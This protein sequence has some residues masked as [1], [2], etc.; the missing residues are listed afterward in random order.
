MPSRM[1]DDRRVNVRRRRGLGKPR[2]SHA[3][4]ALPGDSTI[5]VYVGFKAPKERESTR[6]IEAWEPSVLSVRGK[7]LNAYEKRFCASILS[8]IR[9]DRDRDSW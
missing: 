2:L 8:R 7:R 9:G 5:L 4:E 1:V 3:D 6:D